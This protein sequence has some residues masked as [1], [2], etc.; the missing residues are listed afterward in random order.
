MLKEDL[1]NSIRKFEI[2]DPESGFSFTDR[3]VRENSW[4]RDYAIRAIFEYKRFMYLICIA[5]H[6]LTPSDQVDQVWHLHLLYTES[7]WT[8][9]CQNTLQRNVH[10]GPTKGGKE[11]KEKYS[12]WYEETGQLYTQVFGS[13]PPADIW[14]PAEIRFTEIN[15]TR[16]NRHRNWVIPKPAL[17]RKWKF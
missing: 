16:V 10:H 6:P 8:D 3:L 13:E 15:F 7:Y 11:E 2:D 9:F 14:P 4:T 17:F 5:P 1:W 12:N